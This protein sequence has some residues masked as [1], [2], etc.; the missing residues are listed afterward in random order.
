MTANQTG[1]TPGPQEV[2]LSGEDKAGLG[3][4]P[5]QCIPQEVMLTLP[6][7]HPS[8]KGRRGQLRAV[9]WGGGEVIVVIEEAALPKKAKKKLVC[10]WK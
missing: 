6:R 3:S 10:L 2:L 4:H 1:V 9:G 7:R 5:I 8:P